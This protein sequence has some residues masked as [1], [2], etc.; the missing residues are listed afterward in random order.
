MTTSDIIGLVSFSISFLNLILVVILFSVD[1]R[2][3]KN[4]TK[5]QMNYDWYKEL[6]SNKC[7]ENTDDYIE[8]IKLMMREKCTKDYSNLT[9]IELQNEATALI[10][11]YKKIYDNFQHDFIDIV[12]IVNNSLATNLAE[13]V[14]ETEDITTSYINY[15]VYKFSNKVTTYEDLEH[16]LYEYRNLLLKHI[17]EYNSKFVDSK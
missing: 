17:F 13:V 1:I 15:F 7:K 11:D 10:S 14:D 5:K 3:R 4:E 6:V 16:K 12:R 2:I 9:Q 8:S